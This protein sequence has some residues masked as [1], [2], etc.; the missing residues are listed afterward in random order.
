M[1]AAGAARFGINTGVA[2][3]LTEE[4]ALSEAC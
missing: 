3:K 2:L 4:C 1:I